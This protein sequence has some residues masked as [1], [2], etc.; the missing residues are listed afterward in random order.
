MS[1]P[2]T[3]TRR[4]GTGSIRRQTGRCLF[5]RWNA[6]LPQHKGLPP[7]LLG[8]FDTYRQAERALAAWL[9]CCGELTVRRTG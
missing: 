6:W 9:D 8:R 1:G 2:Q 4:K 7:K 3:F 5:K